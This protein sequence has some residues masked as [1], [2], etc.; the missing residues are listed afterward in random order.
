M[1]CLIIDDAYFRA[2]HFI[3][4][5]RATPR[6]ARGDEGAHRLDRGR[7]ETLFTLAQRKRKPQGGEYASSGIIER[8]QP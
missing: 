5:P 2:R 8:K 3:L 4:M 6:A 1:K 7:I